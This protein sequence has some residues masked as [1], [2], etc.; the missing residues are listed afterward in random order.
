MSLLQ[1]GDRRVP[2]DDATENPA[3]QTRP[4]L[5][6]RIA[7]FLYLIVIV[8]GTF[9]EIFVRGR[10]VVDGDV[11]ATAHNIQAHELLYRSGFLVELSYCICN[12]P[13]IL[14]LYYLF[15]V[16]NKNVASMML[17]FAFLAN[18]LESVSLLAD[19]TR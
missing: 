1:E 6:A 5:C 12:V 10:L 18:A 17:F 7:G 13:L 3:A 14:I 8:G 9:A 16:V 15:K 2:S 11:L 19:F 4:R